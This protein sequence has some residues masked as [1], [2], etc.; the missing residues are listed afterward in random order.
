MSTSLSSTRPPFLIASARRR[1]LA[2]PLAAFVLSAVA[3]GACETIQQRVAQKEDALAAAGFEIKPA[4]TPERETMLKRLP[5]NKFVQRSH[6]DTTHY[7]YADPLVC[8]CLYVGTQQAYDILKE[9]EREQ[10]LADENQMTAQTYSDS[11]WNWGAWG[12]WEHGRGFGPAWG[13]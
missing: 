9:H 4:N 11:T 8:N 5:P 1:A 13:W 2:V 6:G 7:V 3:L 12:P 10:H